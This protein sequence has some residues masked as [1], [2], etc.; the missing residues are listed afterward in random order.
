MPSDEFK[1]TKILIVDDDEPSRKLM[2]KTL[3]TMGITNIIEATDGKT[4][5]SKL[6]LNQVDLVIS[7]WR[8]PGMSGLDFYKAAQKENL[9]ENVPFL[10]VSVE[11]EKEKVVEALKAGIRD[12]IVKP[13]KQ[14]SFRDKVKSILTTQD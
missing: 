10:M 8:M 7:D 9:L 5:I 4:A 6:Y 3:K 14:E 1:N 11:N 12:Y 13:L 2:A